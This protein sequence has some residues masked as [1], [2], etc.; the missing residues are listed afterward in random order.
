MS[1]FYFRTIVNSSNK[2]NIGKNWHKTKNT[3]VQIVYNMVNTSTSQ[4]R[5]IFI[6]RRKLIYGCISL[7]IN[8][9]RGGVFWGNKNFQKKYST[10]IG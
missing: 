5:S 6:A 2:G 10:T 1:L 7:I 3:F 4:N 8:I 9:L